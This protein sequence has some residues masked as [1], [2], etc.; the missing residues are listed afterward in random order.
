MV[1]RVDAA[2]GNAIAIDGHFNDWQ[3]AGA[4]LLMHFETVDGS[5]VHLDTVWVADDAAWFYLSFAAR[6][7]ITAQGLPG[8]LHVLLDADDD[9][10]TGG[11]V[12][13]AAGIDS[14][15]D[16]SPT[17]PGPPGTRGAGASLRVPNG[18]ASAQGPGTRR[19]AHDVGLVMMPTWSARRFEL[20]LARFGAPDGFARLGQTLRMQLVFEDQ[21]TILSRSD[22][23]RHTLRTRPGPDPFIRTSPGVPSRAPRSARV[24][25]WNVAGDRFRRPAR[26]ARLLAAVQ[27]DVVLLDEV[28]EDVSDSS[29]AA[30]FE[31]PMLSALGAWRWVRSGSGG[32]QKTI[33]A[34]RDRPIR[35]AEAMARVEFAPGALDSLRV[36][37]PADFRRTLDVEERDQISA[38]GAW[39][40]VGGMDVL[41]VPLDLR[42][43]GYHGS[44]NDAVRLLQVRTLRDAIARELR[45][46]RAPLVIAGDFNPVGAFA[47]VAE[48]MRG[49]DI[50]GGDLRLADPARLGEATWATWRNPEVDLFGPGRLDLTLYSAAA[51]ER[52]GGFVFASEDLTATMAA[53]LGLERG[54]SQIASDH[55]IVVTDLRP[56]R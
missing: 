44:P 18:D 39:V 48:L 55:L 10:T 6:D 32:R 8:T 46:R 38:T 34:T 20:R 5:A 23:A 25:Q 15:V 49:L 51:L 31:E 28:Y 42:S 22:I 30:F 43:A 50:D 33:V 37:V 14:V 29:L 26:H 56:R 52:T 40:D 54:D 36:I 53:A 4:P 1:P 13:G 16:L 2:R 3:M 17:K 24:A 9:P 19:N 27:P 41:F 45:G 35:P 11:T 12:H 7:T 21:G 47:P